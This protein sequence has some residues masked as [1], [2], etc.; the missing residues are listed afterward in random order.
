LKHPLSFIML[1]LDHFKHYNDTHGHPQG[2]ELLRGLAKI[3]SSAA[4]A[5]IDLVARYGG[6]EFCL[7]LPETKKENARKIAERIR[8]RV[9][10]ASFPGEEQQPLGKVTVSVGVAAMPE[11]ARTADKLIARADAALY[12]AKNAG[13]NRVCVA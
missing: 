3:F 1:D 6:E 2:D 13:R 8:R 12:K 9:M 11:D 7:L 5:D 4:R 10:S